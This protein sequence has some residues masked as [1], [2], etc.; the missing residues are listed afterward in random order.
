[1]VTKTSVRCPCCGMF[2]YLESVKALE[3]EP[4]N[5]DIY[6]KTLGGRLPRSMAEGYT[7]KRG[8][9]GI[10]EWKEISDTELLEEVKALWRKRIVA[11]SETVKE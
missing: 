5:L 4:V 3:S 6:E 10:L 9:V 1:M 8:T 11:A 2:A 7:K